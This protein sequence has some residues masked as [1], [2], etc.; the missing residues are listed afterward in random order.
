M[1]Y[2]WPKYMYLISLEICD[3]DLFNSICYMLVA[4]LQPEIQHDQC[5]PTKH[6]N[7][8]DTHC[9]LG[10]SVTLRPSSPSW[11]HQEE[12]QEIIGH[13]TAPITSQGGENR[14]YQNTSWRVLFGDHQKGDIAFQTHLTKT[15]TSKLSERTSFFG[16]HH[17][18]GTSQHLTGSGSLNTLTFSYT[19]SYIYH[20]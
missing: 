5:K 14:T 17:H 20:P 2:S 15:T 19:N 7:S 9:M 4:I 12:Q 6:L 16:N 8:F 11:H 3:I 10:D 1:C 18:R 13:L